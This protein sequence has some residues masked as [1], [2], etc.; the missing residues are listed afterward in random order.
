M[1]EKSINM[2]CFNIL[3]LKYYFINYIKIIDHIIFKFIPFSSEILIFIFQCIIQKVDFGA[4][5]KSFYLL[6]FFVF[7][8]VLE[9]TNDIDHKYT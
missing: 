9:C 7:N 5:K 4:F 1:R 6:I 2:L 3:Q 8:I